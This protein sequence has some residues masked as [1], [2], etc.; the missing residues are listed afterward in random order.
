MEFGGP[1]NKNING[2]MKKALVMF[3][4][5]MLAC[6]FV[7]AHP[8]DQTYEATIEAVLTYELLIRE[9][10]EDLDLRYLLADMQIRAGEIDNAEKTLNELTRLDP[11]YDMAYYRLA[12]VHYRRKEYKRALEPLGKMKESVARG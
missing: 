3:A 6:G 5:A 7:S 11:G 10:P 4:V 2:Q 1:M 9:Y 12:E 8:F